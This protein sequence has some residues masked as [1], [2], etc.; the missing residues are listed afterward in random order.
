MLAR[1]LT[2]GR[3]HTLGV[4]TF[5]LEYFGPSRMLTGI[6][7][8]AAELGYA[9]SLNLMHRPETVD[10]DDVLNGLVGRQVDG[11]IWAIAEIGGN[12]SWSHERSPNLPVPVMLVGGMAGQTPLP[13]IG[14]D[15]RAI[16]RVATEH[17]LA[18]GCQAGGHRHRAARLVGSQ[19]AAR[20]LGARRWTPTGSGTATG[21]SWR[22]TGARMSGELAL[23][24]LLQDVPDVDAV[25]ASNDQMALGVLHAAHRAGRRVPDDLALVGVDDIPE[26]SHFWPS[27]T[28]VHQPLRDAGA[29]AVQELD[30]WIRRERQRAGDRETHLPLATLLEPELVVRGSSRPTPATPA[31]GPPT[32]PRASRERPDRRPGS[33]ACRCRRPATLMELSW[34][35]PKIRSTDRVHVRVPTARA[36][37]NRARAHGRWRSYDRL[38]P[39]VQHARRRAE[40]GR[41]PE[42]RSR[43]RSHRPA[44]SGRPAGSHRPPDHR[45]GRPVRDPPRHR[46]AGRDARADPRRAARRRPPAARGRARPRQDADDPDA[47]GRHGRLVP[48]HPVHA[49]PRPGRPRRHADLPAGLGQLR[50][51]AWPRVLQLPPRRRDQ[52]GARQGAVRA[53]RGDAGAAGHDRPRQPPRPAAVPRDGDPE[54]DRVRGH[55][56]AAGG[57]GRPVH[58]EGGRRLSHAGRGGHRRGAL[59]AAGAGGADRP[60]GGRP[61]R[62]PGGDAPDLRRPGDHRLR[63]LDRRGHP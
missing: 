7:Q 2:Q 48:A 9:I 22:A 44:G 42:P 43:A 28:T 47:R 61:R 54:P 53:A 17:L 11:I 34:S 31:G 38:L 36:N 19:R 24:R 5:G 33:L 3:S 41:R 25:F 51:G 16:G 20:G 21:S 29:L 55:L 57:A 26:S 63:G 62:A 23:E 50:H 32:T 59:A 49:G 45:R 1:G 4:V 18:G 13:S 39:W 58:D 52:P 12:R 8:Q 60:H 35:W 6:E 14:I 37:R 15:N 10:V 46:R 56:P 30:R 27:L 40:P